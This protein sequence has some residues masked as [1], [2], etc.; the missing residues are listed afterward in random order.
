[1]R[2]RRWSAFAA[3]AVVA[4]MVLSACGSSD[5]GA[6]SSTSAPETTAGGAADTTAA[7]AGG[8]ASAEGSAS[9]G[10]AA[11]GEASAPAG[12]A[13]SESPM[14]SDGA[15]SDGAASGG[16]AAGGSSGKALQFGYV[17]PETGDLAYLGPPQIQGMKYAMKQIN[18]AGGVNGAKLPDPVSGDEANDQALAAQAAD[19]EIKAGVN[20]IIGAAATGMTMA[21]IDKVTTAGVAQC[22]GSNTGVILTDY[23]GKNGLYFRTAPSDALQGPVLGNLIVADGHSNVAILARGDDYGKGLA[24]STADALKAAGATVAL[25]DSYDP[26][27]TDFS[28][29][30]QK[31]VAAKPDA[32]VLI[33]FDEG[34]QIAKGLFQAGLTPS[35]IGVYGADGMRS[36]TAPAD[37]FKSDPS[38]VDGMK[39]TAPASVDNPDFIKG[40]K[41][42]A[43]SLKET[44]YA[45]QVFDCTVIMALAAEQAKSNDAKVFAKDVDGVTKDGTECK[46]FADCKALI[47]KGT[48]IHYVGA[49]GDLSFTSHGEP[50]TASIEIYQYDKT[51]KLTTVGTKQATLGG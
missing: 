7:G 31:V 32:V 18:D 22:S 26:K 29:L 19:R 13:A 21:I 44:Q 10:S 41:A 3:T 36:A 15:A 45:P 6:N 27:A 34:W 30:I 51:G 11:S 42:F 24:A 14:A 28:G 12:G 46:T 33:S 1:M 50:G 23:K 5:S 39:G 38:V 47:D 35:K 48:D 16:A 20:V 40:L 25:N 9:G 49:S 2:T 37:T 8:A 4:A 17:L 43:P